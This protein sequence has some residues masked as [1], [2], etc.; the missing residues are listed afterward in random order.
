[1][2][3]SFFL[4]PGAAKQANKKRKNIAAKAKKGVTKPG[5]R[6]QNAAAPP[7]KKQRRAKVDDEEIASDD[8]EY[9]SDVG[10]DALT[11]SADEAE[12][13]ET[14][15][16]KR[17]RLA[18]QYLSE[19]ERQEAERAEDRELSKS[20]EQRLQTEYLDSVGR[21]R[22]NIAGNIKSCIIEG[23]LKH[24]LHHTPLCALALSADG[25]YLYAGAKSQ[26][27][28]RWCTESGKVLGK[29]DVLPHREEPE[30]GKKRRSHVIAICLSSDM[31][32]MAIA[33]GGPH[34]QIW[35]PQTMKHVKTFKGHRDNVSALVFRKGTHELYSA[36]KDRSVKIWSL[37]ELAYVESLFGHQTAVTSIDA[38]S[39]ERA[40]TAGGSDCSLRIWKITEESQLIYNG[41]KDGIECVKLIN[42]EHFVSGGVDGAI[43]LWSALKKKPICTTQL[44]HGKGDNA[45]ANWITAIAVV[46]NTDLIATG[47]CD[48]CVRLWQAN[49][50]ARKLQQMNSISIGGF[51]NGLT[52]N[53]DG[54]KLY[55]AVG[56]EHRLGRWWRHKDA[57]NNIVVVDIKLQSTTSK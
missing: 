3:S 21:L 25:K 9:G 19:I 50:N 44:A 11:F 40:I 42:D 48:G 52:F 24:K 51:I 33:E 23:N 14:P 4:K 35:C 39:R 46:V 16:D 20:I 54:T 7:P 49:P 43:S 26:Y 55:V 47:S 10:G 45:V 18:K 5:K 57:R 34:I 32:F 38:L 31:K 15:Q 37:D 56:Q 8:D 22:R 29:C 27:V 41:H 2:S 12:E 36:A 30:T 28:L 53:A 1:M 6:T 17:L 13:A